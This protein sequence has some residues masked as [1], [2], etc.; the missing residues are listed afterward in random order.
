MGK[1]ET[2]YSNNL[3]ITNACKTADLVI[4]SI[5]IPGAKAPKLVTE[6]IV[7]QMQPGSVIVDVAIDQG[8][9]V[10]TIDGPT[11]HAEPTFVKHDVIHY[12]VPNIPGAVPQTATLALTNVTLRYA[13]D[14]ANK[15]WKK[16][17]SENAPLAKGLN[18]VD[19]KVVYKSVADTFGMEYTPLEEVL[20]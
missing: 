9:S 3:N 6:E 20:N 12:A 4:S 2:L 7:K 5:L 1:I 17:L 14:I 18:V 15:G 19:G 8:A 16:A 10:E 11:S 13:L